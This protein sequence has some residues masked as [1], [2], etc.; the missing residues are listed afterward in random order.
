[1]IRSLPSLPLT[2]PLNDTTMSS[3]PVLPWNATSFSRAFRVPLR[4]ETSEAFQTSAVGCFAA[5]LK[6]LEIARA[7][8]KL[9][10]LRPDP[11]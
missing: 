3:V 7:F 10:R 1:M 4:G 9:C 2:Y 11:S 8:T 5:Q 6:S